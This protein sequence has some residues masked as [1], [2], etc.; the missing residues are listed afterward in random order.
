MK[1]SVFGMEY[2]ILMFRQRDPTDTA[3]GRAEIKNGVIRL[4]SEMPKSIRDETLLHE[5]VHIVVDHTNVELTE[6]QVSAISLGLFT[7][8]VRIPVKP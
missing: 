2:K 6:A 4:L 3:M 8:G 5:V 7:A 1:I